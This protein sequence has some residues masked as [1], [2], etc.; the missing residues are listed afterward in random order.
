MPRTKMSDEERAAKQQARTEAK[1]QQREA[2]KAGVRKQIDVLARKIPAHV[3]T[4][5]GTDGSGVEGCTRLGYLGRGSLARLRRA[6]K[7]SGR[8]P[9]MPS[10]VT[11]P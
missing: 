7:R 6:A 11:R 9:Q 5:G 1:R 4:G 2:K 8:C 3:V 10:G